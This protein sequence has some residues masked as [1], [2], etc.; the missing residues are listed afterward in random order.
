VDDGMTFD[1]IWQQVTAK[2]KRMADDKTVIKMTAGGLKKLMQQCY[3]SGL[4]YQDDDANCNNV[5]SG[6]VDE[7]LKMF[8]MGKK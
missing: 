4:N 8:G 5:H 1:Q 6:N 3:D 2:D 7:L